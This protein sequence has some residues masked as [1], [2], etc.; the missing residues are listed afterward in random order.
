MDVLHPG[1]DSTPSQLRA[2][3]QVGAAAETG[4]GPPQRALLSAVQRVVLRT[5]LD[6]DAL[7]PI[8]AA[9]VATAGIAPEEAR[10]LVR[11]MV[12][13]AMV[14]GPPAE[15][16]MSLLSGFA[17]ALRVEEPAIEVIGHLAKGHVLRFRLAFLRRSHIRAYMRNTR[18]MLGIPGVVKGVLRFRGVIG[19]DADS[20]SR[21]RALEQLPEHSLGR[22]FFDHCVAA[23]IPFPGEKGG[24]PAGA[25]FHDIT[26]VLSG[27]DTSPEGELKNA[28]FQAGY[29]KG[30]H[31]FFTLLIAVVLHATGINLTPFDMG[32]RRGRMGEGRLAEEV[33]REL[34]RGNGVTRDLG[35]R[36]DFWEYMELPIDAARQRLG[37]APVN[38]PFP[39]EQTS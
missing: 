19:E 5:D 13:M 12:V 23:E 1:P 22:R 27:Y 21:F 28:A 37:I 31:D 36:W 24:F 18:A 25:V 33:V 11:L 4:E 20:V 16:Q 15:A 32:F 17:K 2:L 35:D 3:A 30:E 9:E 8:T 29:T 14:D 38:S 6:L 10:Q 39:Q 34:E 7:E 26:H